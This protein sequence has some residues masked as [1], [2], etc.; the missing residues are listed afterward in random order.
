MALIVEDGTIVS[1]AES[2]LSVADADTYHTARGNDGWTGDATAKEAALRNATDYLTQRYRL[3]WYGH[4]F[5][6]GQALDW[7]RSGINDVGTDEVP[8]EVRHA[9]AEMALVALT[10]DLNAPLERGGQVKRERKKVGPIESE[11]E[12]ADGASG[13]TRYPAV[14]GILAPFLMRRGRLVRV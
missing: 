13:R 5:S 2:Y 8:R 4:R 6:L 7:P 9:T 1:G 10:T 12:Y 14:D 3:N 11:T